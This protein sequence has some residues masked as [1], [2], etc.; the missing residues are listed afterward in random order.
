MAQ[1][2]TAIAAAIAALATVAYFIATIFILRETRKSAEAAGDAMRAAKDNAQ[3]TKQSASAAQGSASSAAESL[4]LMRQQIEEQ[5]DL[6][7]SVVQT[8]VDTAVATVAHWRALSL[9]ELVV[10]R[11]PNTD[12]LVP[13]RADSAVEH[14][15]RISQE[16]AGKLSSAFDDLRNARRQLETLR[17]V[18]FPDLRA[19]SY[20]PSCKHFEGHLGTALE[21]LM[22]VRALVS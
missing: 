6:G 7:R 16:A 8:T 11:I 14:A 4:T 10:S 12:D 5:A 17:N 2:I 3:A 19:S 20:E 22:Q 15:R 21:K 9:P 13:S 18:P 1:W